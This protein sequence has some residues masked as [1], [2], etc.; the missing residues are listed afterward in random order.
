M[1]IILSLLLFINISF[2]QVEKTYH[3]NGKL[4]SEGKY[5]ANKK[6]TGEWK[7]Y[8]S[9]GQLKQVASYKNGDFEGETVSY[10]ENGKLE[11]SGRMKDGWFD[12]EWKSY[13][14]N[15]QL[16]SI[17]KYENTKLVGESKYYHRNGQLEA[18]SK[19][20]NGKIEGDSKSY[21]KNGQLEKFHKFSNGDPIGEWFDY[22]ENG[23]LKRIG[24]HNNGNSNG[25][26]KYYFENG[27]IQKIEIYE[28][29]KFMNLTAYNNDKGEKLQIGSFSDGNGYINEYYDD[30]IIN[31]IQYINGIKKETSSSMISEWN[32]EYSLRYNAWELLKNEESNNIDHENIRIWIERSIELGKNHDN[33]FIHGIMCYRKGDYQLALDAGNEALKLAKE[34]KADTTNIDTLIQKAKE[35]L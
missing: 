4:E 17:K 14:D 25:E 12:G 28:E 1:K 2:A 16:E 20:I 13:Y 8:Y 18:S 6:R 23:Q 5:D 33:L 24:K 11:G 32:D 26:W 7:D 19:Y 15:G 30:T 10:H 35:K 29:G 22:Y 9:N 34:Q 31:R 27:K 21:F 3:E